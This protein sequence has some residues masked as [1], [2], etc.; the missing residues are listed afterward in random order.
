[1][2]VVS[3]HLVHAHVTH[4]WRSNVNV[5]NELNC[6]PALCP[7]HDGDV[8]LQENVSL[9]LRVIFSHAQVMSKTQRLMLGLV[10]SSGGFAARLWHNILN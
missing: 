8:T 1:M 7:T 2:P 6:I 5:N 4:V 10:F 3:C 9:L